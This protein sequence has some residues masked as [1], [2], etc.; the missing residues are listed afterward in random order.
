MKIQ[1]DHLPAVFLLFCML[2]FARAEVF[3][4]PTAGSNVLVVATNEAIMISSFQVADWTAPPQIISGTNS[5]S[6]SACGTEG[7][8]V[9]LAGPLELVVND[10]SLISFRRVKGSTIQ[11]LFVRPNETAL[12][13]VPDGKTIRF[14][15]NINCHYFRL[16][17]TRGTQ[18]FATDQGGFYGTEEFAGPISIRL[19]N[20]GTS[21]GV[22]DF[23]YY[24]TEGFLVLP[25]LGL[26]QGGPGIYE[27]SV[28]K[29]LD[30]T[31]WFPVVVQNTSSDQK[32]FYRL[33][34]SN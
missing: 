33:R 13:N 27:I 10:G 8:P 26:L 32:A 6:F 4:G 7:E 22:Q 20:L 17:I 18:T 19:V 31:N 24:F 2:G 16:E 12:V 29:S 25:E 9:A 15:R 30:L 34:I 11:T 14:F 28:Q 23:S 21:T 5:F 3:I 1:L